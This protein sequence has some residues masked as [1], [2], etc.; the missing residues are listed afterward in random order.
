MVFRQLTNFDIKPSGHVYSG[1]RVHV[2]WK[3]VYDVGT[4]C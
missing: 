4:V 3:S 2:I 1:L